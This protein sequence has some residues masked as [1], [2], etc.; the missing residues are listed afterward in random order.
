MLFLIFASIFITVNSDCYSYGRWI[1]RTC[2]RTCT[3]TTCCNYWGDDYNY[4]Y[5]CSYNCPYWWNWCATGTCYQTNYQSTIGCSTSVPTFFLDSHGGATIG[6]QC[7][8]W[9]SSCTQ[10]TNLN[11]GSCYAPYYKMD[12]FTICQ[13][14]CPTGNYSSTGYY[15][16]YIVSTSTRTCGA[17]NTYCRFCLGNANTC[18]M[19]RS[20]AF[21]VDDKA[22]CQSRFSSGTTT[23]PASAT[24]CRKCAYLKT[25]YPTESCLANDKYC[26]PTTCPTYFYFET[27][28]T[29]SPTS[30]VISTRHKANRWSFYSPYVNATTVSGSGNGLPG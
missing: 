11:C 14:Y 19:C 17:C 16:E 2:P 20:N 28:Y 13:T 18:Y 1:D 26:K 29:N 8:D 21:L 7:H 27:W 23:Q 12:Q 24:N 15:G 10:R 22:T 3:G 25:T 6:E 5:D 30:S 4:D 9:C